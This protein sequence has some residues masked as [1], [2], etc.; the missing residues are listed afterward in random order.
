MAHS[1]PLSPGSSSLP[2]EQLLQ[3]ITQLSELQS[4]GAIRHLDERA[5]VNYYEQLK[6]RKE[7]IENL[8]RTLSAAGVQPPTHIPAPR[9]RPPAQLPADLEP[10]EEQEEQ[11]YENASMLADMLKNGA[12]KTLS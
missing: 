6:K 10:E 12:G 2:L 1:H 5:K 8:L 11:L 4:E 7:D 3:S 9:V